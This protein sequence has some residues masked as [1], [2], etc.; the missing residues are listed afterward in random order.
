MRDGTLPAWEHPPPEEEGAGGGAGGG[1]KEDSYAP[2]STPVPCGRGSPRWSAAGPPSGVPASM[3]ELP[4]S[5]AQVKV[6]PPLSARSA[7]L[8][9]AVMMEVPPAYP[10]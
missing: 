3:A 7:S 1:E 6:G 4:V 2:M 10:P 9:S 8:G 5:R